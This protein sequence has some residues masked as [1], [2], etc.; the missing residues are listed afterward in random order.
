ME[1]GKSEPPIP[2]SSGSDGERA[3]E[4]GMTTTDFGAKDGGVSVGERTAEEGVTKTDCGEKDGAVPV[5]Q[6]EQ[7]QK[8]DHR[9]LIADTIALAI[10]A[11]I[12]VPL[13]MNIIAVVRAAREHR[14]TLRQRVRDLYY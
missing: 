11:I 9:L 6:T 13:V 3:A 5:G 7:E 1:E 8:E 10:C 2:H 14:L 4:E 12:V